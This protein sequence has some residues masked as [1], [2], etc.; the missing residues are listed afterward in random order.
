MAESDVTKNT[1]T[2]T[3]GSGVTETGIKDKKAVSDGGG[4]TEKVAFT[5]EQQGK[6]QELIDDAYRKAF[7]KAAKSGGDTGEADKLKAELD[8]MK[9]SMAQKAAQEGVQVDIEEMKKK[10]QSLADELEKERAEKTVIKQLE[11]ERSIAF[12]LSKH[13]IV[14][15]SMPEVAEL[16]QRHIVLDETGNLAIKG[17][18]G[19]PKVNSAGQPMTVDEFISSWLEDR[20]YYL[21]AS[22]SQGAGS[23][24]AGMDMGVKSPTIKQP[25]DIWDLSK[26]DFNRLLKEGV[27]IKGSRGQDIRF[28]KTVNPFETKTT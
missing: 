15:R 21:R 7:A 3:D 17:E 22:S 9:K 20:P 25:D 24:G 5:P 18:S 12:A 16:I 10:N 13:D 27:N 6:V 2:K 1:D 11:K 19:A 8:E 26:E 4:N 14:Q 28:K 23:H